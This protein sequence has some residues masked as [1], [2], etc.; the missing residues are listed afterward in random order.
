[1]IHTQEVDGFLSGIHNTLFLVHI[2]GTLT[3]YCE[4]LLIAIQNSYQAL[5]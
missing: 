3:F 5:I 4:N 2:L 1:M